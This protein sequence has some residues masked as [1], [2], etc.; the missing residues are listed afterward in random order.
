M[1]VEGVEGVIGRC[2]CN[3]GFDYIKIDNKTQSCVAECTYVNETST[4][5]VPHSELI[6]GNKVCAQ[7][8]TEDDPILF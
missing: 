6:I 4:Y 3:S 5:I 1:N 7:Q 2:A 8:T